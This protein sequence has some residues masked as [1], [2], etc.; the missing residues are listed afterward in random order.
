[1][2]QIE[3]SGKNGIGKFVL[4]DD[5]NHDHL[6]KVKWCVHKS[7]STFY[8]RRVICPHVR[9]HRLIMNAP[10]GM[11]VDHIDGNGLNNQKS[12]LRLATMSQNGANRRP[13]MK[14]KSSKYLG[15]HRTIIK[16]TLKN[17]EKR[18]CIGWVA[19]IAINKKGITIGR[20]KTEEEAAKAY[21]EAARKY[22][23]DFANPNFK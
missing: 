18:S 19:Q 5:E 23:G 4:V 7:G 11:V 1:M 14:T 22:H 10:N 16:W 13:L 15:V 9:M 8:A 20:F 12:N 6:S 3:L 21:D 17:G 2:K